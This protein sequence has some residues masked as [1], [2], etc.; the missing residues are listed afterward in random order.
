MP[1]TEEYREGSPQ[2]LPPTYPGM[3]ATQPLDPV[4]GG[5]PPAPPAVTARP[6][7]SGWQQAHAE[8]FAATESHGP[9][10]RPGPA[11]ERQAAAPPPTG[12][13]VVLS[14]GLGPWR[15]GEVIEARWL[16]AFPGAD[17]QR[18]YDV[19]AVRPADEREAAQERVTLP[20]T[21]GATPLELQL[22]D[23]DRRLGEQAQEVVRLRDELRAA[24]Q[25]GPKP[26]QAQ[27]A[28]GPDVRLIAEK[29]KTIQDLQR[30][31]EELRGQQAQQSP[32]DEGRGRKGK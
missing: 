23:R 7:Q 20:G 12:K 6:R 27:Q 5:A 25:E 17:L 22:A 18:L 30:Q 24:K 1:R 11:P 14:G 28:Q 2:G 15:Q 3:P 31:L 13:L 26:P 32:P 21:A 10:W 19:E 8:M 29:D 16:E 9:P 4:T